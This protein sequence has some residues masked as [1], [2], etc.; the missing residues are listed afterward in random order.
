MSCDAPQRAPHHHSNRSLTNSH[1]VRACIRAFFSYLY[2][3]GFQHR[4]TS[5]EKI[6]CLFT[7][8]WLAT[9]QANFLPRIMLYPLV[10]RCWQ[11]PHHDHRSPRD[12]NVSSHECMLCVFV[13]AQPFCATRNDASRLHN[14]SRYAGH[15]LKVEEQAS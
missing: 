7:K 10:A 9:T 15:F 11:V 4:N 12:L 1:V 6:A 2:L 13:I 8:V 3:V 14:A 5:T